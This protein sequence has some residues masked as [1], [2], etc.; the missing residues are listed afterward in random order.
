M[1]IKRLL[2]ILYCLFYII[3]PVIS[4]KDSEENIIIDKQVANYIENGQY[5]DASNLLVD[6]AIKLQ[7]GGDT[8]RALHYQLE[9][10][11]LIDSHIDLFRK[12]GL[13]PEDYFANWYITISIE[14]WT[15]NKKD[16]AI[17]LLSVLKK[18]QKEAPHLLPFYTS[19]LAYILYDFKDPQ[20]VDSIY[21]LQSVMDII[22]V[23][24]IT[25]ES[26][27]QYI[28]INSCFLTNRFF[29]SVDGTVFT[30]DRVPEIRDWYNHNCTFI[31]NLDT[32]NY[33]SEI[34]Q[35]DLEYA[36]D[37]YLYGGTYSAQTNNS[38]KAISLYNEVL[39]ILKP[40]LSFRKDLS[41]K[42]SAC[43]AKISSEYYKLGDIVRC[44]E[45]S[46][47]TIESLINHEDNFEYCDILNSIA[48]NYFSIGNYSLAAK[49]K[50]TEILT[51]EKL[52]WKCSQ[53]D[54]SMY[55][56]YSVNDSPQNVIRLKD[57]ALSVE[58]TNGDVY[59]Y[60]EIGKAY[61]LLMSQNIE[62]KDSAELFLRKADSVLN[63]NKDYYDKYYLTDGA[64]YNIHEEWASHYM[65]LNE[66][67]LSY[68]YSKRALNLTN[69]STYIKYCN[70]SIKA[71]L[72]H[73]IEGIHEYLPLYY[74]GMEN[75][76]VKMLPILGSV[77][78]DTY[79]GNGNGNLYHIPEWAS[80]NPTDSVSVCIAYDAALLMKGLTLRY[81][82]L[83]PYIS[84]C[85]SLIS[86]KQ[87]LSRM[88]DSIYTINNDNQRFLALYKY[89]QT[90]R[91][92]LKTINEKFVNLHWKDIKKQ[93]FRDEVCIEF[94][95]YT[96]NAYSWSEGKKPTP[97]YAAILLSG[98]DNHPIFIDL[99]DEEELYDVYNLQPKSY[100]TKGG[101]TIYDR[102]WGKL[103]NY[104]AGKQ[105]VFFS[106][107]GMLN[108]IN[109]EALIDSNGK[110]ALEA[111]HL[112]RVSSTRQIISNVD[113]SP[114]LSVVSFGGIDYT[115]MP[116]AIVDSLN[117]RGNW[118]YLKSTLTEVHS[119]SESLH[120]KHINVTTITGSN[121]TESAFKSLDDTNANVIHI[122]SHGFYIS[123]S[124]RDDIQY[125]VQSN[126]TQTIK[127]ELFY[128]GL[129]MSGGQSAWTDSI[130][131][132]EKDDGILTSYEISKLNLHNVD[133]VVLSACETGLGNNLFD[134]IFG[135]QRAFK[136][137]GAKSI[138]MSL[139]NINDK[140][141]SEYMGFFYGFLA[142]GLSK[143]ESYRRTI[144]EMKKTH[145][146]PYFWASF[147]L[148][149]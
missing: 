119:I 95:K 128:S 121:A 117:T 81:E 104:I 76:L 126:Y 58:G 90:E 15:G 79:L 52:G 137:A 122:A 67:R 85:S 120:R 9:N 142:S 110:T 25:K 133:L 100:S 66:V 70:A 26:V 145:A 123:P 57:K 24:P 38:T 47:R 98:N 13:T 19:S 10:C 146:D 37:L 131:V 148:L 136:K 135:L 97:H 141:T 30:K 74:Y 134:G 60:L 84:D 107:T 88:R 48:L 21:I 130:F 86:A 132:A 31:H 115:G 69:D 7:K 49:T 64:L 83:A 143:Q 68:D 16:G 55:F 125:Y 139:W 11:H 20:Y 28:D 3:Q 87:M 6:Y 111:Y 12:S 80:W 93:L 82:T 71:A 113:V 32:S 114:I 61:S 118:N 14:G 149:D 5:V 41:Q 129:I 8:I 39:E 45:Y 147:I 108:L 54:W 77:E 116:E 144:I 63:V 34:L 91:N 78:S 22:K 35:Y 17:H 65:R 75:D 1:I 127:D 2:F 106:P 23:M 103:N 94:L 99:F 51:R 138:L 112:V 73:D 59:V 101:T 42:I 102:I 18:M 96:K 105:R 29:N 43:Y 62:Y 36:D 89:E 4:Q 40:L 27:Q 50:L 92:L 33:Y 56:R 140:A 53:S 44:K 109:I 124:Q 72:L 46:D